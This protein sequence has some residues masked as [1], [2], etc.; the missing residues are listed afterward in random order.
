MAKG[1]KSKQILKVDPIMETLQVYIELNGILPP[2]YQLDVEYHRELLTQISQLKDKFTATR[3]LI[4]FMMQTMSQFNLHRGKNVDAVTL[5]FFRLK[6]DDNIVPQQVSDSVNTE[7]MPQSDEQNIPVLTEEWFQEVRH[8]H[9]ELLELFSRK[10]KSMTEKT[11]DI[12]ENGVETAKDLA[13]IMQRL[14]VIEKIFVGLYGKKA[15][16]YRMIKG[17]FSKKVL[18]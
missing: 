10:I 16:S 13:L 12:I 6:D 3:Q 17:F 15:I 2:P 4:H 1:T 5:E 18:T 8:S 14:P 9:I 7:W 11:D